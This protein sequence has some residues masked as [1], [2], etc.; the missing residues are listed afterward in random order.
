MHRWRASSTLSKPNA[1]ITASTPPKNRQ[2]ETCSPTLKAFTTLIASTPRS[3]ISAPP[4]WSAPQLNPS[5]FSGEDHLGIRTARR[6][7]R[8]ACRCPL[9][10]NTFIHSDRQ[11]THGARLRFAGRRRTR[12]CQKSSLLQL[13]P[14]EHLVGVDPMC[15]RH[16][17]HRDPGT[18]GLFHNQPL[19]FHSPETTNS[20]SNNRLG[21]FHRVPSHSRHQGVPTRSMRNHRSA[22]ETVLPPRLRNSA[23][24]RTSFLQR[25]ICSFTRRTIYTQTCRK[26]PLNRSLLPR[27][28]QGSILGIFG[29]RRPGPRHFGA[30]AMWSRRVCLGRLVRSRWNKRLPEG[31]GWR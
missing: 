24:C 15:L 13:A 27:G 7:I 20:S 10:L 19:L 16:S 12:A 1:C 9:P 3:A 4:K 6:D 26:A 17:R 22:V 28:V 14:G 21:R 23:T 5:T 2:D 30:I 31:A 8:W 25:S 29:R 18:T 11:Q